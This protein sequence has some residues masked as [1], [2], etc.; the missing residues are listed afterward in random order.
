MARYWLP[1]T[2]RSPSGGSAT[3]ENELLNAADRSFRL[4]S[5]KEHHAV[6]GHRYRIFRAIRLELAVRPEISD[7]H[8][9][10][11][12]AQIRPFNCDPCRRAA[13]V[14]Q[15]NRL[16]TI[17]ERPRPDLLIPGLR[18]A[19]ALLP[20]L[21]LIH[22]DDFVVGENLHD[23]RSHAAQIVPGKQWRGENRPQAHMRSVFVVIHAAVADFKH[24]RI[25]PVS[26]RRPRSQ[27]VL[28]KTDG[29]HR[30][31]TVADVARCAPGIAADVRTPLPHVRGN[32]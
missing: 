29:S 7:A 20:T 10:G 1:M 5:R 9:C 30:I 18:D 27:F 28:R 8:G 15:S 4:L 3:R 26:G 11:F 2:A 24:V 17:E 21:V 25:V 31:P 12:Q 14:K 16:S 13:A 32:A 22:S 6:G 23:I 19:P